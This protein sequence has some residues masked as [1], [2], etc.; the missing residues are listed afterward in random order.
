[1]LYPIFLD[2]NRATCLIVG[3]GTVAERKLKKLIEAG[4]RVRLVAPTYTSFIADQVQNQ[5]IEYHQ[6]EYNSTDLAGCKLVFATTN[7]RE[8]NHQVYLDAQKENIWC[9]MADEQ[10]QGGFIVPAVVDRGLLQLAISSSGAS[11]WLTKEVKNYLESLFKKD[12]E[13]ELEQI[14]QTR[15]EALRI[16]VETGKDKKQLLEEM[17]RPLIEKGINRFLEP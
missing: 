17:L 2:L 1:M 5:V 4:A 10:E 14:R 12:I 6:R 9:N 8:V 15:Q 7:Q 3:G 11:P 13:Q 16:A